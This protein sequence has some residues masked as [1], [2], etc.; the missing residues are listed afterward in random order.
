MGTSFHCT[1]AL[2]YVLLVNRTSQS[3]SAGVPIG[4]DF[5]RLVHRCRTP[6]EII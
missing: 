5:G 4:F 1:L 3:S 6:A 2:V